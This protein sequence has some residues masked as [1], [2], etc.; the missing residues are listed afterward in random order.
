MHNYFKIKVLPFLLLVPVSLSLAACFGSPSS[1]PED[2]F[3]TLKTASPA[4]RVTK[5]ERITIK[6]VHAYGLYNE[7]ALLYAKA[8]LPLQ[9]KRYHYHHWVMPPTQLIQHS[10]KDYLSKSRIA[11]DVIEQ[12]ISASKNL[13]ISAELLAFERVIKQAE[14]WVQVKLEFEVKYP[15]GQYQSYQYSEKVKTKRDTIHAA[16]E[17]YGEALSRIY[18]KLLAEL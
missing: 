9:I 11:T 10:L 18:A 14:Q 17:A 4:T 3:Y 7:R 2:R 8:E 12:A 6:K 1:V 13:R 15:N 5:Y 16:A